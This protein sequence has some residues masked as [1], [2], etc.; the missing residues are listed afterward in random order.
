M[1]DM[2][3]SG[4]YVVLNLYVIEGERAE[5]VGFHEWNSYD[6]Y[7]HFIRSGNIRLVSP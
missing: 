5:S 4:G 2:V 1:L 7:S 3:T 6:D